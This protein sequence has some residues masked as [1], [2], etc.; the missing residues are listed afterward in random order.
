MKLADLGARNRSQFKTNDEVSKVNEW[1]RNSKK[2][3]PMNIQ[4]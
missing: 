2:L 4:K 3:S 1:F